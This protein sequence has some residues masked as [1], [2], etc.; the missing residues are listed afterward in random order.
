MGY[1]GPMGGGGNMDMNGGGMGWL[2]SFNQ[3]VSS[4][5]QITEL[6]GMNAEALNFC[7]GAGPHA[8]F[9]IPVKVRTRCCCW[10]ADN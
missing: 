5:G 3:I 7:I 9:I 8:L 4:I 10:C 2:S 1:G 6:L